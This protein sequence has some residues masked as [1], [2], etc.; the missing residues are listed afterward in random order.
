MTSVSRR[1]QLMSESHTQSK[2]SNGVKPI[3]HHLLNVLP[4]D[5]DLSELS[6]HLTVI[7][8]GGAWTIWKHFTWWEG[9]NEKK[10]SSS[11][12]CWVQDLSLG[13][14]SRAPS[15]SANGKEQISHLLN[16]LPDSKMKPATPRYFLR[17]SHKC[18]NYHPLK[19]LILSLS[20]E[21]Y[22]PQN[23]TLLNDIFSSMHDF[24]SGGSK[25]SVTVSLS[26]LVLIPPMF[27]AIR[28]TQYGYY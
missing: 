2:G 9:R 24:L 4:V 6:S 7:L 5:W 18:K 11:P 22:H 27:Y 3:G 21:L 23:P 28:F 20:Y 17:L 26:R 14:I 8:R 12:I 16:N 25:Y 13:G 10:K 1:W 15:Q 19:G